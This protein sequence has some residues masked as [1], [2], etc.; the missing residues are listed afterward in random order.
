MKAYYLIMA[1]AAGL[2]ALA[3]AS[4]RNQRPV[5]PDRDSKPESEAKAWFI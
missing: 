4:Q 3:M 1:V 5:E 2:A